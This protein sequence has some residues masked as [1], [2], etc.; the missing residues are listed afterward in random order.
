M[1][2][3]KSERLKKLEAEYADLQ[4]WHDLGLVP[5]K[6]LE[7]HI[8][9]ME[10]LKAK[11]K[12]ETERLLHLKESGDP[13]EYIMP[14]RA[15]SKQ[16]FQDAHTIPDI[17]VDDNDSSESTSEM[18]AT[19]YTTEQA[20]LFTGDEPQDERTNYDDDD[21]DPY[22]DKNRWRRGI[23]EDPDTNDW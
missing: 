3:I 10:N 18:E 2:I 12:D 5:K 7:K 19:S 17:E 21:D 6:D 16:P 13:E 1:S 15:T 14:K 22:S 11:V 23:L 9:E 4:K 20:T 8:A